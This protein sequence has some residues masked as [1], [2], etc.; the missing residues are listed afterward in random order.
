[1]R[2]AMLGVW[3]KLRRGGSQRRG[4]AVRLLAAIGAVTAVTMA[5]AA[6]ASAESPTVTKVKPR[7]GPVAGGTTVVITGSDFTGATAVNFGSTSATSFTVISATSITAVSPAEPAGVVDVTVATPA[8]TTAISSKD[9]FKFAPTVTN[10]NPI[11]GSITGGTTVTV[12]GTGFGVGTTAT[13][14]RF[15]TM[16]GTA[17]NCGSNTTCTVVTPAHEAGTIVVKAVVKGVTSVRTAYPN[18]A[19]DHFIYVPAE[20]KTWALTQ[21]VAEHLEENPLPDQLANP[22]VW[23]WMYGEADTPSSNLLMEDFIPPAIIAHQCSTKGFHEWNKGPTLFTL[24]AVIYNSGPTIERGQTRCAPSAE[25][26][27]KTFLM[28]PDNESSL[29]AVV[30]WKSPITGMVTVSGS[31]QPTDSNVQGIVWQLDR[32]STILLGPTEQADTSLTSFGP[33][34]VSVKAGESLYFDIGPGSVGGSF[35]TTAVTLN[36]TR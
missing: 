9:R 6:S 34:A 26:P 3:A 19:A 20:L 15:G 12:S 35:D 8:G 14:F 17:V 28:H 27:T 21:S 10:V 30:R 16:L 36:V 18:A 23:S 11:G 2:V 33:T 22:D 13:K 1:M 32:G 29:A 25:Y 24:P 31:V 7:I 4:S 5:M